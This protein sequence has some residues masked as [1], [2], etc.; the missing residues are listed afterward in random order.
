[1]QTIKKR[2]ESALRRFYTKRAP[3]TKKIT[4]QH[5]TIYVL[6]SRTGLGFFVAIILLWLLGTNYQNNLVLASSFLLISLFIVSII[7]AFRNLSGLTIA[8]QNNVPVYLG[9]SVNFNILLTP[10]NNT[11][12]ESL[13]LEMRTGANCSADLLQHTEQQILLTMP[14]T[15]RGWCMAAPILITSNY[16]LGIVKVWSW[17]HLDTKA[18]VYPRAI[19]SPE[20]LVGNTGDGEKG[21]RAFSELDD[22]S[23]F[24][25]YQIGAPLAHVAWKLHARG[26]GLHLKQY[27]ALQANTQWLDFDCVEGD[28]ELRLSTLCYWAQVYNEQKVSFGLRLQSHIIPKSHGPIHLKQ[29]LTALA[30]YQSPS[31][32]I[33]NV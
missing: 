18:L 6:P 16:P 19:A 21:S 14:S 30:L 3:Q 20:I 27:Q 22:F 33:S 26:A 10:A 17:V 28:L 1:M 24:E 13:T 15:S 11:Q 2:F 32:G 7:H 25:R 4:L 12:H 29:V 9:E 23:G 8:V 31:N 5:R